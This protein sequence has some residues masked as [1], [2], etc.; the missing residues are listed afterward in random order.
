MN[1]LNKLTNKNL[2]LNKNRTLV[3]IIGIS[4]AT[5]LICAV[6]G[7][8]TSFQAT[9]KNVAKTEVGDYHVKFEN[10]PTNQAKYITENNAVEKYYLQSD[11]GYAKLDK[12]EN[13]Y[14]PYAY[15]VGMS[16]ESL[17]NNGLE[18]TSGRLPE[19]SNEIIIEDTMLSGT[20]V[21]YKVGDTITLNYGTRV[22]ASGNVLSQSD[23]LQTDEC[24]SESKCDLSSTE[25]ITNTTKHTYTI[26]GIISRV[27]TTMEGYNAPGYTMITYL[28]ND[29]LMKENSLSIAV[30]YKNSSSYEAS[31][32][33]I[34]DVLKSNTGNTYKYSKNKNLLEAEGN[35]DSETLKA[36]YWIGIIIVGIIMVTGIFTTRNA[37][38]I[39]VS[40]KTKQYGML[41]SIGA[42]SKQIKRSVVNEGLIIGLFAIPLGLLIGILATFIL[43][44]VVNFY[45]DSMFSSNSKLVFNIPYVI[46]IID[47]V[48]SFITIYLSCV[49]PAHRASK[50]SP[51]E[52]I[53]ATDDIK[54]N[55]KKLRTSKLISNTLGIGGII[56]D[57]NLKRNKKK[58]STT[59]IS[60]VISI[61]TFITLFSFVQ[62]GTELVSNVYQN[63]S[64]NILLR[65]VKKSNY[66]EYANV[67]DSTSSYYVM[68]SGTYN[69]NDYCTQEGIDSIKKLDGTDNQNLTIVVYNDDYFKEYLK[70][71]GAYTDDYKS[72]AVLYDKMTT[73]NKSKA[74]II[75]QFKNINSITLKIY[76]DNN[77]SY[78]TVFNIVKKTEV[79]PMGSEFFNGSGGLLIV[80]E[81][82][83]K[84]TNQTDITSSITTGYLAMNSKDASSTEKALIEL[85]K[86]LNDKS[87]YV[88]NVES[89]VKQEKDMIT[90]ISIFL[91]GF[92]IV[93]SLIGVT[94]VFNT[95]TT[96][97]MLR[98]KEFAMLK[99][100]GMTHKEF[101][102][103]IRLESIMYGLKSL[104]IGSLLGLLGSYGIYA[105]IGNKIDLGY[106][107][108]GMGIIISIIFVVIIIWLTMRYSLNRV[109]KQNIIETIRQENI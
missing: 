63:Y 35:L 45:G 6:L 85:K 79:M 94:N 34:I 65:D 68:T 93:I 28:S 104:I 27:N 42:T 9:M 16:S 41:S 43:T 83:F 64:F 8:I 62:Y 58:Y 81:D 87:I 4:L 70:S 91:Y 48:V 100:I 56:A 109:N 86:S 105:A 54:V 52:A 49:I 14:K 102:H 107:F 77:S 25:T 108:P 71:I 82:Y 19:N 50:I 11:L 26:V 17:S 98:S 90:L 47:A 24:E 37:F 21:N 29:E 95:I 73:M 31:S 67:D 75:H 69:I 59:I 46:Y 3:T 97:M 78:D 39:S 20:L 57:K 106:I 1:I 60:L 101:N 84:S 96:S 18:L 80:S 5:A 7:M 51:I 53:R 23:M 32:T 99:S 15:I 33:Y 38:A 61:A 88:S 92:I 72:A 89:E 2:K 12:S 40:E 103:M 44:N 74:S 66:K 55:P 76:D 30:K 10:I 22:D 13:E 36:L